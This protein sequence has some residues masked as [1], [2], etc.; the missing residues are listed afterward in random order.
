MSVDFGDKAFNYFSTIS[1]EASGIIEKIRQCS[2]ESPYFYSLPV[3][4]QE[5]LLDEFFVPQNVKEFY[6][7]A[8]SLGDLPEM[9]PKM[10]MYGGEKMVELDDKTYF[11][12]EFS[13][14]FCW[15]T[16]VG[17]NEYKIV[18]Y[19]TLF[20]LLESERV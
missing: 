12:D 15:E 1:P 13:G 4:K 16:S 3:E 17:F 8:P 7:D 20:A 9:F 6:V 14:P 11:R 2:N 19:L 18:I 5:E 10:S